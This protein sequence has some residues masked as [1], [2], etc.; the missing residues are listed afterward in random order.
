[1]TTKN[2]ENHQLVLACHCVNQNGIEVIRGT[3]TV[4]APVERISR[5]AMQLPRRAAD[6]T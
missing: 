4:Q 2:P 5:P 1:V 6:A 3:A